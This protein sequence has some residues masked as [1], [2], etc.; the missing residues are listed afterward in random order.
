MY[1]SYW[2]FNE[3][4]LIYKLLLLLKEY[5][6]G[7][8]VFISKIKFHNLNYQSVNFDKKFPYRFSFRGMTLNDTEKK[9]N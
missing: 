6:W 7:P 1:S 4:L 3:S 9:K 2:Y 8:L 5:I